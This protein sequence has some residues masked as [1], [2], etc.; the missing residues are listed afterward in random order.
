MQEQR[1]QL[2]ISFRGGPANRFYQYHTATYLAKVWGKEFIV[3]LSQMMDAGMQHDP[4]F[5]ITDFFNCKTTASLEYDTII[6]QFK[7]VRD[8]APQWE[9]VNP[10]WKDDL[11]ESPTPLGNILLTDGWY[12]TFWDNHVTMP[13]LPKA[14]IKFDAKNAVFI[15]VRRGDYLKTTLYLDLMNYY[16][17]AY[18]KLEQLF[19]NSTYLICSDDIQ[20]CRQ[21][22]AFIRR[23]FF[24]EHADYKQTLYLMS[25]CKRGAILSNSTFGLWGAYL[26]RINCGCSPEYKVFLPSQWAGKKAHA[27]SINR[28]YIYPSWSQRIDVSISI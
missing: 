12:Q 25:Q 10:N 17:Q 28:K 13:R 15:H 24:L 8:N 22:L 18:Q 14:E 20:W 19:E 5:M 7:N 9:H 16:A 26:G 11:L 1:N 23:P 3:D 6:R 4:S 21:H 27:E 2:S